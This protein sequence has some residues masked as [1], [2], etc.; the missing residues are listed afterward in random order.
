MCEAEFELEM[1]HDFTFKL[2]R[3]FGHLENAEG[4]LFRALCA[5]GASIVCVCVVLVYEFFLFNQKLY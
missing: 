3:L 1:I 5:L 4:S 2:L